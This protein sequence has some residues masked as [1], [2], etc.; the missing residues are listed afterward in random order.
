[1]FGALNY[2]SEIRSLNAKDAHFVLMTYFEC[3]KI[4]VII[5]AVELID[6]GEL[7]KTYI[8]FAH[9]FFRAVVR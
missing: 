2:P 1:M 4:P 5:Q 6:S 7:R 8:Q 9:D 3:S